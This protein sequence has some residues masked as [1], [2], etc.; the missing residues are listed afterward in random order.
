MTG[1]VGGTI[2]L[3]SLTVTGTTITQS[4]TVE[5]TGAVLYTGAPTI[6]GNITTTTSGTFQA[7][8]AVTLGGAVAIDTSAGN[9][10][11]TFDS[12]V[13]GTNTL[14][15]TTGTGT[16]TFTG[17]VGSGTALGAVTIVSAGDVTASAAIT[18]ASL[19]QSAGTGTTTLVAVNTSAVG[20]VTD[21][22]L[23][24]KP[25]GIQKVKEVHNK[26]TPRVPWQAFKFGPVWVSGF[27]PAELFGSLKAT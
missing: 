17:A 10:N 15:L 11:I 26:K 14:S 5:T 9:Q 27:P 2:D 1:A 7:T 18:A 22:L 25:G 6:S 21:V 8:G 23:G 20:G 3:T 13:D 16:I 4:S 24:I 12:T 19:T